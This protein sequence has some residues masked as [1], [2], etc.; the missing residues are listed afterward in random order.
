MAEV[1][2]LPQS[3]LAWIASTAGGEIQTIARHTARREAWNVEVRTPQGAV[4]RYFL[5]I[6][7]ALAE[8]RGSTRNLRREAW[9]IKALELSLSKRQPGPKRKHGNIPL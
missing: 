5:R 6:D 8:G 1:N 7:R 3:L 2:A 4:E 9:L